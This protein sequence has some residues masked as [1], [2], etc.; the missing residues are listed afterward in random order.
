MHRDG[1]T[2]DD[3][4]YAGPAWDYDIAL[5]RTLHKFLVGV[6]EPMQLNAEGWYNDSIGYSIVDEPVS[7][8]QGLGK[9]QSF[10]DHVAEVYRENIAAFEA[11]DGNITQQQELIRDSAMMNFKK[12]PLSL[13]AEYVVAPDIMKMLGTGKYRLNYKI[14]T[15]WD[16][17]IYNLREFCSKRTMWLTDNLVDANTEENAEIQDDVKEEGEAVE[18]DQ[19]AEDTVETV[20]VNKES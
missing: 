4:L 2:E 7:I 20:P 10:R 19:N 13:S 15:N 3:K 8:L 14:T 1:L 18:A 9:H 11:I 16:S 12:Y 17:F 6:T 5:G